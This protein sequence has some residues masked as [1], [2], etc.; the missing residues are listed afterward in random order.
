M[1]SAGA[2]RPERRDVF[3]GVAIAALGLVITFAHIR[4]PIV[5]NALVYAKMSLRLLDHTMRFA[6]RPSSPYGKG[7]GF[8]LLA[9][10]FVNAFGPNAGVQIASAIGSALF[11]FAT[12]VFFRRFAARAGLSRG[13]LALG[14]VLAGFNPL[15][16]YQFWSGYADSLFAAAF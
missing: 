5:R 2:N 16:I 13:S 9:L 14:V 8:P 12:V 1:T 7:L 15:V 10:P 6:D 11:I 4:L 3:A